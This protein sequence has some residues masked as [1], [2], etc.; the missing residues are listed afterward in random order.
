MP[1]TGE[2]LAVLE[3]QFQA[4]PYPSAAQRLAIAQRIG[5]AVQR[6]F[7]WF[8][9]SRTRRKQRLQQQQHEQQQPLQ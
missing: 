3:E 5:V 7:H 4:D 6:V 1:F 9:N 2:Q 8:Q